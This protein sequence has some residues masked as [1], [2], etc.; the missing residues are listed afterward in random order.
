MRNQAQDVHFFGCDAVGEGGNH[1][2]S[3]GAPFALEVAAQI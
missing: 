2:I 3:K 1:P